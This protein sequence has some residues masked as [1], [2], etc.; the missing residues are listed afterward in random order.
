ME[1]AAKS[2]RKLAEGYCRNDDP[3]KAIPLLQKALKQY[4]DLES[5]PNTTTDLQGDI[6]ETHGVLAECFDR[7]GKNKDSIEERKS[8]KEILMR[9]SSNNNSFKY[10]EAGND[11]ALALLFRG[12]NQ[13]DV[14]EILKSMAEL[15][16]RR[17]E[18]PDPAWDLEKRTFAVASAAVSIMESNAEW[19]A[20]S[21]R[22]MREALHELESLEPPAKLR[23]K[24]LDRHSRFTLYAARR[25][26]AASAYDEALHFATENLVFNETHSV[27]KRSD[28]RRIAFAQGQLSWNA[29]LDK[30]FPI[31]LQAANEA[32]RIVKDN[33]LSGL[34]FVYL[35]LAHALLLNDKQEEAIAKYKLN[36]DAAISNDFDAMLKAGI[37]HPLMRRYGTSIPCG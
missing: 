20:D 25:S 34:N 18:R 14:T 33:S 11:Y 24:W 31:A 16:G 21:A 10:L 4:E 17:Q 5:D 26:S 27:G 32:A 3:Q 15:L 36:S 1:I 12:N 13:K 28:N 29:L 9:S 23:D 2:S 8:R 35:N 22:K 37:C 6:A 7:L 30:Q 19:N